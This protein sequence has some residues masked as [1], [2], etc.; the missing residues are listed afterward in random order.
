MANYSVD[1][2]VALRGVE[3]LREFERILTRSV[4]E[5]EKLERALKK[6]KQ[7]NPYDVSGAKRVTEQDKLRNKIIKKQNE[8]LSEQ[9]RILRRT[10]RDEAR[11]R[12]AVQV[13]ARRNPPAQVRMR[14]IAGIAYPEGAGPGMGPNA[15]RNIDRARMQRYTNRVNAEKQLEEE[16]ARIQRRFMID[17]NNL[18]LGLIQKELEAEIEKI[19]AIGA[20]RKKSFKEELDEFDAKL[21]ARTKEKDLAEKTAKADAKRRK[22]AV[23]SAIIGGAFPLLFGQGIGASVGGA[24]GGGL[25]GLAGGQLG[26]GL[27]LVGTAVGSAFDNMTNA[28]KEAAK[29]L[30]SPIANFQQLKDM[31]ILASAAQERYVESLIKTGQFSKA[32][33]VIQEEITQKLGTSGVR[34]LRNLDVAN[35][36][37]LRTLGELGLQ[38]SGFVAGPLAGFLS[39][40]NRGLG[41]FT[42]ANRASAQGRSLLDRLPRDKQEEFL[43]RN[44]QLGN[45][46]G[47][48]GPADRDR[49][50]NAL[51]A[52]FEKF[53]TPVAP[54]QL[55]AEEQQRQKIYEGMTSE[56]QMQAALSEKQLVIAKQNGAV[57]AAT[58]AQAASALNDLE[59]ELAKLGIKNQMLREGFDL[60]R[61]QALH[62]QAALDHQARAA[63]IAEQQRQQ[64][65]ADAQQRISLA[66][67]ESQLRVE[68]Y[69]LNEQVTSLGVTQEKALENR[70]LAL[71]AQ[72]YFQR[73]ALELEQQAVMLTD[74]YQNNQAQI[75]R[76]HQLQLDNLTRQQNLEVAQVNRQRELLALSRM[77]ADQERQ[78]QFAQTEAGFQSQ[79]A[80]AGISQFVGPFGG[81]AQAEQQMALDFALEVKNKQLE[82]KQISDQIRMADG[83]E[84]KQLEERRQGLQNLLALYQEYQPQINAAT[85]EQQRFNEALQFTQPV[86][87]SVFQSLTS[88]VDGTKTAQQAFADFLR[89]IAQMLMQAATQM[90]ATY[91]AIG[92]AR[93][94]AGMGGGSGGASSTPDISGFS[95]YNDSTGLTLANFGGGMASGGRVSGGTSYLV[96]EKG[97]ELFTPGA[98]GTITPNHAMGGVQ[99]GSINITVENTGD[100]LSPAAQKQI[101]NQVQGIV[102]STLVNER[103][104]GGLLR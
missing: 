100:Q 104:S 78:L 41:T 15:Q 36:K 58:R 25:G 1:I 26:F 44:F 103:R 14:P 64:E 75:N 53:A 60:E 29:A 24:A 11:E 89:T 51:F 10:R 27:S 49:R 82:I 7:Q 73:D 101:A 39:A 35:S 67:Q 81:S 46:L 102:M 61:N 62:R 92:V 32:N 95:A 2:E 37:F 55:T 47:F 83:E 87:D 94:F 38:L 19:E 97:P 79:L 74:D 88:V 28:A 86:V 23:S 77:R 63:A 6:V 65:I 42:A 80:G 43:Q 90:I 54:A 4:A 30:R 17:A 5:L 31:S 98:S 68:A 9:E 84:R 85:L 48:A 21:A 71:K 93:M 33:A 76:N 16:V 99:V 57:G 70:L 34:D 13:E 59:Y 52:E 66:A 50:R 8:L 3:K 40:M 22:D 96:G 45:E 91:I 18:E 69:G 72:H 20:A 56:L 12:L